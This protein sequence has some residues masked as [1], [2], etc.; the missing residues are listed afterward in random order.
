[1]TYSPYT[2]GFVQIQKALMFALHAKIG[3]ETRPCVLTQS[4]A[5][6]GIVAQ[7]QD[8]VAQSCRPVG[9]NDE[10]TLAVAHR[11]AGRTDIGCDDRFPGQ[12]RLEQSEAEALAM[13]SRS[14]L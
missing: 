12:H 13:R 2:P 5:Q 14:Q 4:R 10:H 11:I 8:G 6:H 9:R 7:G 3:F 1:M